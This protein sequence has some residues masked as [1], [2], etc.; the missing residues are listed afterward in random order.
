M[1]LPDFIANAVDKITNTQMGAK[2]FEM[3]LSIF[4]GSMGKRYASFL[5]IGKLAGQ[6]D[7]FEDLIGQYDDPNMKFI[8]LT[9]NME[10]CGGGP[11]SSYFEG[12]IE[13]IL[14]VKKA[15]PDNLLIFLGIDPRWDTKGASL[16]ETVQH[17][18]ETKLQIDENTSVYPFVG[19]KVY[20]STG[21]YI[22]DERLKETLEWAADNNIPV[23]SHCNYLGG[24]YNVDSEYVKSHLNNCYDPYSKSTYTAPQYANGKNIL[25]KIFGTNDNNNNLNS[26]SYYLE[27]ASFD[28]VLNY[29]KNEYRADLKLCLAHYGGDD[30]ILVAHGDKKIKVDDLYGV[31]KK[32]WCSQIQDRMR[33]FPN[34]YTDISFA[35]FN[36]DV[37]KPVLQD[38]QKSEF[39]KRIMFGTDF[40]LTEQKLP[41]KTDYSKFKGEAVQVTISKGVSAWDQMASINIDAFL[42]SNYYPGRV[43]RFTV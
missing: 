33:E 9:M 36:P 20:P 2:T 8:A 16:K 23:L 32:D 28:S 41:E 31:E 10:F 14:N 15:H 6:A 12:Q 25:K 34:L 40:F 37:H 26:C 42:F 19:L 11:S 7:V 13:E 35:V 24:I 27:P 30:H 22:F 38:L 1:F 21:F 17:Y 39:Q 18:F 43:Q 5:K 29:F 3:I 4:P